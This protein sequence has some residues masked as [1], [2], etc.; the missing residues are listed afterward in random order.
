MKPV[1]IPCGSVSEG[2]ADIYPRENRRS[3]QAA[4]TRKMVRAAAK[5]RARLERC[6]EAVRTSAEILNARL[7]ASAEAK[8][9]AMMSP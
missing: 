4:A 1:Q 2:S 3:E 8:V 7:C 9:D 6:E 5:E